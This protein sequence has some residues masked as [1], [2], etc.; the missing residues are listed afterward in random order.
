MNSLAPAPRKR[1]PE[2]WQCIGITSDYSMWQLRHL[3]ALSSVAYLQDEHQG[4]HWEWVVSFSD[5]GNKRLSDADIRYCLQAFEAEGFEEDNH[6]RGIARKFW[7]A[8]D[9]Q[10]RKPCP[11]KDETV[12]VEGDYQYSV[13][14]STN[15]KI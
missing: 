11:C 13:K 6:E 5:R 1:P 12:I 14:E 9:P 10:Y 7:L 2:T 15:A 8:I 3:C 4:P